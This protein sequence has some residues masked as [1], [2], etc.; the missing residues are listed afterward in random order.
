MVAAVTSPLLP[1]QPSDSLNFTATSTSGKTTFDSRGGSFVI[2]FKSSGDWTASV[3]TAA[4]S[5]CTVTPL[6]GTSTDGSV[7]VTAAA[8][9]THDER[10]A[11]ITL[12]CGKAK[13]TFVVVQKQLDA[14]VLDSPSKV[15][16]EEEGGTFTVDIKANVDVTATVAPDCASWIKAVDGRS[17]GLKAT[18]Y[19]FEVKTNDDAKPRQGSIT[20]KSAAATETVEV[21]QYGGPSIVLSQNPV[22]VTAQ[23]GPLQV[24]LRSNCEF[25]YRVTAG[26]D[27]LQADKSRALSS[28]TVYF[29]ALPNES[30]DAGREATVLFEATNGD[31][32]Q[33]LTVRQTLKS[34]FVVT[35]EKVEARCSS[36][37]Y[38][39]GYMSNVGEPE[40]RTPWWI[41]VVEQS[42]S[43]TPGTI[44]VKLDDNISLDP[45][46]GTIVLRTPD[47]SIE[48]SVPVT[49]QPIEYS[50]ETSLT[51]TSFPDARSHTFT[52][53]I[54]CP[55]EVEYTMSD[56]VKQLDNRTFMVSSNTVGGKSG[57][58][59]VSIRTQ[60]YTLK[61]LK[62]NY[63]APQVDDIVD[64]S[65]TVQS[66][67]GTV[68][69]SVKSNV[70]VGCIT[71]RLPGWVKLIETRHAASGKAMD[72]FLFEVS[73]NPTQDIRGTTMSFSC[74]DVWLDE[75]E[76]R[77]SGVVSTQPTVDISTGEPGDLAAVV[78][79]NPQAVENL[80]VTGQLNGSDLQFLND[81][82]VNQSL[83]R[84]DISHSDLL[85]DPK[86]PYWVQY[87][88]YHGETIVFFQLFLKE[89]NVI[90]ENMFKDSK[91]REIVLSDRITK[92]GRSAFQGSQ[93]QE[94]A[95][96][97]SVTVIEPTALKG[98]KELYAVT[99]PGTVKELP[100]SCFEQCT[101]LE[102]V[103]L[104]EGIESIGER[105]FSPHSGSYSA[106]SSLRKLEIP[107][108]VKNIGAQA[109]AGSKLTSLTI[110]AGVTNVGVGAMTDCRMLESVKFE[111]TLDTLHSNMLRS[112][113]SL[114]EIEFPRGLKVIGPWALE[115]L[116]MDYLTIPEGV[117]EL[118]DYA[119]YGTAKR[120]LT[121]PST[122]EVIGEQ[123]LSMRSLC[124]SFTIPR[125]VRYMGVRAL[126]GY[127]YIKELHM[128]C[129]TPPE[130]GGDLF[131]STFNYGS[132]VLYVPRGSK[133]LY[134]ADSYWLKFK[135]IVEE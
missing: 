95:I 124:Y 59:T 28:H 65:F 116:G 94:I 98:C 135:R 90:G 69:V 130:R 83:T 82:T 76:L 27:W 81:L 23:G 125:N 104:G 41:K 105:C 66:K 45:R 73:P 20:F 119:L 31:Y 11:S 84:L 67:A 112:C 15:E 120:G 49:Q 58:H 38:A 134:E 42:R 129:K 36:D 96:P 101:A 74:D 99:V 26:A 88:E 61:Q 34:D 50:M 113:S 93:L 123:A 127:C 14:M 102:Q 12:Q 132:C 4:A 106:E 18:Q 115:H 8:N 19:S 32:S 126:G 5:W 133:E 109:F 7:T 75:V 46:E 24:E 77:Q 80:T 85:A 37:V 64:N 21:L 89:D 118:Q 92:L 47:G 86:H 10:N 103:T 39:I 22:T 72:K 57:S 56:G 30:T 53:D 117:V 51:D 60:G 114:N 62:I 128:K 108:T 9:T 55:F 111:C 78:G 63:E 2:T 29:N 40:I 87:G 97:S 107:S 1:P 91:L 131:D 17:R 121:L 25:T 13:A 71:S 52:I 70:E 100:Y 16:V 44:Y 3:P 6:K 68:E 110:P 33:E 35:T 79:D 54:T 43:L 122:L 48:R